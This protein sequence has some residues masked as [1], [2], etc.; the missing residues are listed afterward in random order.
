MNKY[1]LAM[2]AAVALVVPAQA[3]DMPVKAPPPVV[4]PLFN[5][6]G[7][8]IGAQIGWQWGKDLEREFDTVTGAATGFE[9]GF[10]SNGVVGGGHL[11]CN[12]QANAFVFG[13]E[14][15]IEASGVTG[16]FRVANGDGTDFRSKWQGSIRGRLGWAVNRTLLYATGGLAWAELEYI[17][18]PAGGVTESHT[19]TKT[20]WTVGGGVEQAFSGNWSARVEYRYT[21]YGSHRYNSVNAFPGFS[22]EHAPNFH[23]IRGYLTYRFGGLR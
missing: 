5:W 4:A 9:Q 3:A 22:Y 1:L 16:S 18:V 6:S 19:H 14:G 13:I 23:A 21:E 2:T 12:W 10:N 8:Y 20:G 15:D 17:D 11:G 7:C